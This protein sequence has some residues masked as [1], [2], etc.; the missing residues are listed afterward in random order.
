MGLP[1]APG[2][3]GTDGVSGYEYKQLLTVPFTA[4][5]GNVLG[6]IQVACSAGKSPL[7]GG[8]E[9]VNVQSA[10][11]SVLRSTPVND[12]T[13]VGWRVI[14]RNVFHDDPIANAQVRVHVVCATVQ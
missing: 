4:V 3:N 6:P 2:T 14:V 5:K 7:G 8:F 1:G 11:L 12:S 13:L 9:L 10:A